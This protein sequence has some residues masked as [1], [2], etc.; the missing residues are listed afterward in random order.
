MEERVVV[1]LP[2]SASHLTIAFRVVYIYEE[3]RKE[4]DEKK[5]RD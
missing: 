4:E 3:G 5:A 1:E 2:A